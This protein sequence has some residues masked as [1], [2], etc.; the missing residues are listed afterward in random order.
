LWRSIVPL[1]A[2]ARMCSAYLEKGAPDPAV[3]FRFDQYRVESRSHLLSADGD[4]D[5]PTDVAPEREPA[6]EEAR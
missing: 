1:P 3:V 5:L 2:S 4:H 6:P